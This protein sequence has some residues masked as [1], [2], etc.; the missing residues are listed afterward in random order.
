M[1]TTAVH[2]AA[3]PAARS[4]ADVRIEQGSWAAIDEVDIAPEHG[5]LRAAWYAA[6]GANSCLVGRDAERR[7]IIAIPTVS[8]G[9]PAIGGRAVAGSYWPLRMPAV[10]ADATEAEMLALLADRTTRDALG[11]FWRM[12]PVYAEDSATILLSTATAKAGWTV[13]T[14]ELGTTL[15]IDVAAQRASGPWPRLSSMKQVRSRERRPGHVTYDRVEGES[16]SPQVFDQLAAIERESWIA[17]Q[18]DGSGAKFLRAEHRAFWESAVRDPIL[19][20][21]LTALIMKVDGRPIAFSFDLTVGTLQ[22]GIASTYSSAFAKSSP[23]RV[24]SWRAIERALAN[25]VTRFDWGAG[26][27]GYKAEFGA[28]PAARI[29]DLLFVRNPFL[30]AL[31]RPRWERA[32][33][34]DRGGDDGNTVP[35]GLA[36]KLILGSL[37]TATTASSML[38]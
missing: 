26:D 12:G 33:S 6:A 29:V 1:P 37:I 28:V 7:P 35:I 18:T 21:M 19:A 2:R 14:R 11:P 30:A 20:R 13:L 5:F 3:R 8:A 22:Y 9:P 16:W 4:A 10:A 23:G 31:L 24:V 36:E 15:T 27:S 38:E 17:A 25:G 32:V 34:A